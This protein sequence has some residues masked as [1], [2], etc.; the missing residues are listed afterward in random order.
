VR[1][2][3][4]LLVPAVA[5]SS[6]WAFLRF[7]SIWSLD[8]GRPDALSNLAQV[9]GLIVLFGSGAVLKTPTGAE[10][11]KSRFPVVC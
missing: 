11:L 2:I 3:V 7:D 5:R 1:F 8:C 4:V 9:H 10:L 6:L